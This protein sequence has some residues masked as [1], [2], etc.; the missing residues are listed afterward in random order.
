[1]T[2]SVD[3][4]EKDEDRE[5]L[6]FRHRVLGIGFGFHGSAH[7]GQAGWNTTAN[8]YRLESFGTSDEKELASRGI[9]R[10][11]NYTHSGGI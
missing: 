7:H 1:M 2:C 4:C 9:E 3:G 8:E 5:G 11:S 10:A 6:C